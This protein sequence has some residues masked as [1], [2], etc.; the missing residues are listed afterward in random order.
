MIDIATL[1]Q[2][3]EIQQLTSDKDDRGNPEQVWTMICKRWAAANVTGT[4]FYD[5]RQELVKAQV[6]F[7]IRYSK[8]LAM[9][10]TTKYRIIWKG[11]IYHIL[12]VD[13][14]KGLNEQLNITAVCFDQNGSLR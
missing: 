2:R 1:N 10:D 9:I 5:A 12:F 14:Y 3:I 4:A 7:V 11:D 8:Q 13:N 6:E